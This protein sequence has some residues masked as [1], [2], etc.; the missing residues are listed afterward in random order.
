[1]PQRQTSFYGADIIK[2]SET[3][4]G[5]WVIS[6]TFTQG[7]NAMNA[8]AGKTVCTVY[9]DDLAYNDIATC[10]HDL[11]EDM[12]MLGWMTD[13]GQYLK[14]SKMNNN[15]VWQLQQMLAGET[16]TNYYCYTAVT[17]YKIH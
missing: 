12:E 4:A 9:I 8:T 1:L 15:L 11:I 10:S 14:R 16:A 17:T 7:L 3:G 2:I 5:A 13:R 6:S